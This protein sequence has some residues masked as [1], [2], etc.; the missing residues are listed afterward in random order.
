MNNV[1]VYQKAVQSLSSKVNGGL[2]DRDVIVAI[3]LFDRLLDRGVTIHP[4]DLGDICKKA[5]LDEFAA[6]RLPL[7]FDVVEKYRKYKHGEEYPRWKDVVI[8]S[9]FM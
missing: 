9:F 2:A 4:D 8:D 6:E 3:E 5:C 7:I 1:T